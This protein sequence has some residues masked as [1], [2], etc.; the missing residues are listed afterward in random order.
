M[1]SRARLAKGLYGSVLAGL[2]RCHR[3]ALHRLQHGAGFC[4]D[5][6]SSID[7]GRRSA[8]L[9]IPV[10]LLA[11]LIGGAGA[12]DA[13]SDVGRSGRR[14]RQGDGAR[15]SCASRVIRSSGAS[16]SG[17]ASICSPMATS[18]PSILFGTF[19]VL[20]LSGTASI[21]AKRKRKMGAAWDCFAAKTSNVPFAA[22]AAGRKP[23][24]SW[25]S[26]STGGSSGAGDVPG[27]AVRACPAFR[28]LAVP[29]RLGAL[30][31]LDQ[32]PGHP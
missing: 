32:K 28:R 14:G 29:E 30:L 13:Q 5:P 3:L 4:A 25:V 19:F 6:P 26:I 23:A 8:H 22:I 21:D 18:P 12:V 24:S 27:R 16:R 31:K 17:R 2:D 11:F 7:L 10:V 20:A 9:A 15:R 1:R